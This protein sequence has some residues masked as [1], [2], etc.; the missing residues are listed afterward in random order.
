MT[1]DEVIDRL[2]DSELNA[3]ISWLWDGGFE[4]KLGDEMNGFVAENA[5]TLKTAAEV[6]YWLDV[7]ARRHFP[8]SKYAR[9]G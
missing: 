8:E 2:Y 6:A 7:A 9:N 4:V 3:S 5:A 1:L